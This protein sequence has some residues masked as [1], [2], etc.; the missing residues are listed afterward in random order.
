MNIFDRIMNRPR[1]TTLDD[2]QAEIDRLVAAGKLTGAD[3]ARIADFVRGLIEENR[4]AE[5]ADAP[6]ASEVRS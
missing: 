3:L 6:R 2:V 1:P 4:R 5:T